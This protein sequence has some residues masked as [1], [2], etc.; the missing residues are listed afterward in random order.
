MGDR[1]QDNLALLARQR[2]TAFLH[3]PYGAV[4][5]ALRGGGAESADDLRMD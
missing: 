1:Q 2:F 4:Q 5:H 3:Q